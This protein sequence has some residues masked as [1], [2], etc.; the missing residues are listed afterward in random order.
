MGTNS[1]V[2]KDQPNENLPSKGYDKIGMDNDPKGIM[3]V[4]DYSVFQKS[5]E[6]AG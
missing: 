3:I 1:L 5:D 6:N 4:V 2:C